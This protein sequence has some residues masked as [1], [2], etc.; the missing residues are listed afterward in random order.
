MDVK[1][2]TVLGRRLSTFY[3]KKA[4]KI[5]FLRRAFDAESYCDRVT[6]SLKQRKNG[7]KKFGE[8]MPEIS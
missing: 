6:V 7:E 5:D 1:D 8:F 2:M 3:S 4:N